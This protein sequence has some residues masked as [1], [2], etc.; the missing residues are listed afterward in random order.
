L[1]R[2]QIY[3]FLTATSRWAAL[4]S[5]VSTAGEFVLALLRQAPIFLPSLLLGT[6]L[7]AT[8]IVQGQ[9]KGNI[10]VAA[11]SA[12]TGFA[13]TAPVNVSPIWPTRVWGY[14]A[15]VAPS[16]P[17]ELFE[18]GVALGPGNTRH[19]LIRNVGHGAFSHW[20]QRLYFSSSD[21][22]DPRTNG[23][24]YDYQVRAALPA[25]WLV[26]ALLLTFFGLLGLTRYDALHK[27][28]ISHLLARLVQPTE[29]E[30][31]RPLP[32]GLLC[33]SAVSA[34]TVIV[35]GHWHWQNSAHLGLMGYLPVS[36]ALGY[37][38]CALMAGDIDW[39]GRRDL[40]PLALHSI[41]AMSGGR[42]AL[43]LLLQGAISGAAIGALSL[44]VARACGVLA[45]VAAAAGALAFSYDWSLGNFMTEALG[46][47]AGFVSGALLV[48]YCQ[49]RRRLL[50][51]AGISAL[52]L[53]LT[54]RAGALFAL[55]LVCIWAY[56]AE[57]P[58]D[59]I[60]HWRIAFLML[61][62]AMVGPALQV[63]GAWHIGAHVE[64][65]GGNFAASLYG[66]STGARDWSTAY[67]DFAHLF[68]S[69]PETVAFQTI[70][71]VAIQNIR[72]HP[73]VFLQALGLN[74]VDF[75]RHLFDFV[76]EHYRVRQMCS[77]LLLLGALRCA[78]RW[79]D[80][81]SWLVAAVFIGE[82][83]S[84]PLIFDTGGQRG[85]AATMWVRLVLVG[86]GAA[87][88]IEL[89]LGKAVTDP[90]TAGIRPV[91]GLRKDRLALTCAG[92]LILLPVAAMIPRTAS[93]Q[94]P[95]V[96]EQVECSPGQTGVLAQIA[97]ESMV[98]TFARE[99]SS[100]MLGPIDGPL[101]VQPEA[102]EREAA[103]T[104]A[105]YISQLGS[106]PDSS[107]ILYAFD[108]QEKTRGRLLALFWPGAAPIVEDGLY[109]LCAG[110]LRADHTLADS[111]LR[112]I[113]TLSR[114]R[115]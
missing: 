26:C 76:T 42:A 39:C 108:R 36:D 33:I 10:A 11:M 47:P 105:W 25:S 81:L 92:V 22:T 31:A 68:Q 73:D 94:I 40:Y 104:Q 57:R 75:Q 55:P 62:A 45:G 78:L 16:D 17:L 27:Q 98:L 99:R 30:R 74:M 79:R 9:L 112:E 66:L 15:G 70:R 87:L 23:R 19:D 51:A 2:A 53:A 7:L 71:D 60:L 32:S 3:V 96:S 43:A 80:P 21:G 114:L 58:P 59:R 67:R 48:G 101:L 88:V 29:Q 52:S 113:V 69:E 13:S 12:D 85:L 90:P 100:S 72:A 6:T 1:V 28:L 61:G 46:A 91:A 77:F 56:A 5:K 50:L 86:A 8:P 102:L 44:A 83:L 41:L 110:G 93:Q 106:L 103:L 14:E 34:C 18:N 65:V 38:R 95:G 82:L 107:S 37:F 115:D 64:N 24:H 35:I 63:A 111:P 89:I 109:S 4:R 54:A 84:V 20:G 49:V 97:R